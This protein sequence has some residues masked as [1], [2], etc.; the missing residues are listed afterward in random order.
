M[1]VQDKALKSLDQA[2]VLEQ[3]LSPFKGMPFLFR[4]VCI[5]PSKHSLRAARS[6]DFLKVP[7]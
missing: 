1:D 6:S 2:N 3:P 5:L 4:C 7:R